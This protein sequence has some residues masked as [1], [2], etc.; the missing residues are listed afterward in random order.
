MVSLIQKKSEVDL[1]N[2]LSYQ[3]VAITPN[4]NGARNQWQTAG[5]FGRI[6]YNYAE[7]YLAELNLRYDG[8]SKFRSD[9]MWKLFP[10][11]IIRLA[12]FQKRTL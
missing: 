6:N 1:T 12:Y 4:V 3:G 11:Y 10:F 7:R 8:T 2:G 5:F 9:K